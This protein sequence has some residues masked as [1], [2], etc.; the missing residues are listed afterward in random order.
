MRAL[1]YVKNVPWNIKYIKR[2]NYVRIF[3]C[4]RIKTKSNFWRRSFSID[5]FLKALGNGWLIHWFIILRT[6]IILGIAIVWS[7]YDLMFMGL[8]QTLVAVIYLF[9]NEMEPCLCE[10]AWF[11]KKQNCALA[12]REWNKRRKRRVIIAS[13]LWEHKQIAFRM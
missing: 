12:Y 1:F 6:N 2:N 11:F 10:V 4:G 9:L 8:S 3:W 13:S 5:D 7:I